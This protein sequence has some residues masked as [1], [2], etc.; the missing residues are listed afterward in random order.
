LSSLIVER[1]PA[2][3][4]VGLAGTAIAGRGLEK[5][6]GMKVWA[7][8]DEIAV[9]ADPP[10]WFQADGEL[11]GELSELHLRFAPDALAVVAPR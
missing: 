4:A 8:I 2:A 11:L 5:I 3:R 9:S 7:G 6:P 10:A 1:V